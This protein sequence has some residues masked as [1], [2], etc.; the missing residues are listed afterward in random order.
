MLFQYI[1]PPSRYI[2][3]G[4]GRQVYQQSFSFSFLKLRSFFNQSLA[5]LLKLRANITFFLSI[6]C[7]T[8]RLS[9]SAIFRFSSTVPIRVEDILL[10]DFL[11]FLYYFHL[12]FQR[13]FLIDSRIRVFLFF[14]RD[15]FPTTFCHNHV[16]SYISTTI[17]HLLEHTS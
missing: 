6:P 12:T 9:I 14:L 13:F 7:R 16:Y 10:F 3:Q 2:L 17:I 11:S 8:K 4:L 15:V 1:I 5:Y